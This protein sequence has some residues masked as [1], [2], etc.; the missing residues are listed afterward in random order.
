[1]P[2]LE[3]TSAT[4]RDVIRGEETQVFGALAAEASGTGRFLLP[5]THSKW[6]M[7]DAGHIVASPPT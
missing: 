3:T 1:M 2:G 5:G 6:V 4:M 7:A